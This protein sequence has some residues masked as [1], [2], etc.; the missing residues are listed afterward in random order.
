L[1]TFVAAALKQDFLDP[2][3]HFLAFA[4]LGDG[5][6]RISDGGELAFLLATRGEVVA[7]VVAGIV[8]LAASKAPK[9]A[10]YDKLSGT[11]IIDLKGA[12]RQARRQ[13]KLAAAAEARAAYQAQQTQHVT[14]PEGTPVAV[15]APPATTNAL[16]IVSLVTGILG[17]SV[18]AVVFGHVAR[19]QIRQTGQ[20]G[21]GM[22]LAGLILGYVALAVTVAAVVFIFVLAGSL[23]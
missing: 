15:V 14:G 4:S 7:S 21:T 23:G 22:A 19:A 5:L 12:E 6:F 17:I 9:R 3:H 2:L 18:L 1:V 11:W 10:W 16:A 8:T 13:A 20:A